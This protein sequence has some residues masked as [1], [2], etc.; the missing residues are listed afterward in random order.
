[1]FYR[2][3]KE[4]QIRGMVEE[5]EDL[6]YEQQF[7]LGDWVVVRARELNLETRLSLLES[8]SAVL[9]ICKEKGTDWLSDKKLSFPWFP[10]HEIKI[11]S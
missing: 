2:T 4:E 5:E 1:M 3:D 6:T 11:D 10:D 7:D 8:I 9:E